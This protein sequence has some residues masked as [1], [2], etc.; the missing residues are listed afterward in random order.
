PQRLLVARRR[1]VEPAL[2]LQD[3]GQAV[4]GLIRVGVE[5]DGLLG[6]CR[7]LVEPAPP[8]PVLAATQQLFGIVSNGETDGRLRPIRD[9]GPKIPPD[10]R[11][12]ISKLCHGPPSYHRILIDE[13]KRY[14]S[15]SCYGVTPDRPGTGY[16]C[17][18]GRGARRV[19]GAARRP[20]RP[21]GPEMSF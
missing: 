9:G 6:V 7:R 13:N 15:T 17:R 11:Q 2:P 20:R 14:E 21:R 18:G 12:R 10:D 8:R 3:Q 5:A 16:R 19:R 4:A 1:L